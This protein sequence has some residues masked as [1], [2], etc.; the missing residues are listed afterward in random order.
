MPRLSPSLL[1]ALLV[2]LFSGPARGQCGATISGH[3]GGEISG[4]A[5]VT[6]PGAPGAQGILVARGTW[7]EILSIAN[8]SLPASFSPIRRTALPAP[9]MKVAMTPGSSRAY[10]LLDTGDVAVMGI[11]Y[12]PLLTVGLITTINITHAV[13]IVAD[14][15][16]VYVAYQNED[17]DGITP[18]VSSYI[19]VYDT[20]TP[21]P[22]TLDHFHPLIDTYG[23]DR[24]VRIGATLWAG[25]HEV[26]STIYGVQA[27]S[28]ADPSNLAHVSAAL[29]NVPFGR[30]AYIT[31]MV[32]TSTPGPRL[33]VAYRYPSGFIGNFLRMVDISGN[34]VWNAENNMGS[35]TTAMTTV[36]AVGDIGGGA[37][38]RIARAG[39]GVSTFDTTNAVAPI[40]LGT[41]GDGYSDI[42]QMI[43]GAANGVTDYWAAGKNGLLTMNSPSP[44]SMSIR[45]Q[46]NNLPAGPS[47]VRQF[48]NTTAVLDYVS[49]TL[50]LFDYTLPE[51]QQSRGSYFLPFYSE[52][53]ELANLNGGARVL[54][55]V[56]TDGTPA[57]QGG[58]RIAIIEITNPSAPALLSTI[59]GFH[60]SQLSASGSRLYAVTPEGDLKIYELAQPL[61]P[62][63]CS[64]LSLNVP[65]GDFT[66]IASWSNNALAIG[67]D[68]GGVLLM[69]TTDAAAP[70]LASTYLPTINYHVRALAKGNNYLYISGEVLAPFPSTY[71]DSRL[72][73]IS[74]ANMGAPTM[75]WLSNATTGAGW[76]D[77]YDNL[78]Y[79]SSPVGKFLIGT[80]PD[81]FQGVDATDT[82]ISELPPGILTNEGIPFPISRL[83]TPHAGTTG[84][85]HNSGAGG[86]VVPNADGSRVLLNAANAGLYQIAMPTQWAPGFGLQ[87]FQAS[88]C[89]GG[90]TT[91]NTFA[92]GNPTSIAYQWVMTRNGVT[93]NDIVDGVRPRG[94]SISGATTSFLSI[95]N[96]H[97]GEL[98]PIVYCLATNNCGT[99]ASL[100]VFLRYCAGDFNCDGFVTVQDIFD[101][102]NSWFGATSAADVN[103]SSGLSVQDI[104]DFLQYWFATC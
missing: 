1:L 57:S 6:V 56:G 59:T 72:E 26:G 24:L 81:S 17:L 69:D 70:V 82:M 14:G 67:T 7:L 60:I 45:A 83:D 79:V 12:S 66:A 103:G 36:G 50:R 19:Q 28:I 39:L 100:S 3:F 4:V 62:E 53:L 27:I 68:I 92:S 48:G 15:V 85:G 101:F 98:D 55:C 5:Q 33:A 46:L 38:I 91:L 47:K 21:S 2:L 11:S 84:G 94:T 52:F 40:F 61:A 49:N 58:D 54:A 88:P 89:Y 96:Y 104:F 8:P 63:P 90:S 22:Q 93:T 75:R 97:P 29:N 44:G 18:N 30:T 95:S 43:A 16:R 37:L 78:A 32:A 51:S 102:L 9:A 25:F 99:T 65:H 10:A 73:S 71:R 35:L 31:H 80:R 23:Y 77:V 87:P 41:Y 74:V 86:N 20:S 64:T 13:D 42:G 76:P 34:P